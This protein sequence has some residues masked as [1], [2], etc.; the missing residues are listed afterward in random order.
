M[1]QTTTIKEQEQPYIFNENT[2]NLSYKDTHHIPYPKSNHSIDNTSTIIS[3][4]S[5][6]IAFGV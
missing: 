6:N 4:L 2:C 5:A 3:G 1:T